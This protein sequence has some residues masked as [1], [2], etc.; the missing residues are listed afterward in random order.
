MPEAKPGNKLFTRGNLV[1][2]IIIIALLTVIFVPSAKALLIRGLMSVGLFKADVTAQAPV[3]PAV[4]DIA[5]EDASGRAIHLN[6]L[7]GKVVFLNFWATW[8]P[9]CRAEMPSINKLHQKLKADTNI[10]FVMVDAD[11]ELKK[12]AQFM[13]ANSYSMP[14]YLVISEVPDAVYGGSLP[15]TVIFDKRGRIAF[16]HDGAADYGTGEVKGFLKKLASAK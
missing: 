6:Q 11:S 12:A 9:P 10:V 16:R 3:A 8:C 1:N 13:T 15:T 5:F 4:A 7:K 2:A 14:L